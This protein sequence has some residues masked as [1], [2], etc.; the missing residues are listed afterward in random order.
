MG[1]VFEVKGRAVGVELFDAVETFAKAF[2]KIA[3]S[4]GLDALDRKQS[5]AARR[6]VDDLLA[7]VANVSEERYPAVGLGEDI[8]LA[9]QDVQ[10]GALAVA[11]RVLHLAAFV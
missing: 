9:S 4:Y 3:R 1:A 7:A 11:G 5:S 10:G 6:S 2:P 8:R